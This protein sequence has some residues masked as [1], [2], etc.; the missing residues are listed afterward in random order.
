MRIN[1][2]F[3]LHF[4]SLSILSLFNYLFLFKDSPALYKEFATLLVANDFHQL[5]FF[6]KNL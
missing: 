2:R 3:L 5:G 1:L 4:F 6:T